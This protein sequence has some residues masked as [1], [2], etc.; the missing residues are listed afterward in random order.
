MT[1]PRCCLLCGLQA[2]MRL[3]DHAVPSL[4]GANAVVL[5]RSKLVGM[6]V[7]M[8]L[9]Q[10]DASVTVC[11]SHTRDLRSHVQR[12]DVVVASIGQAGIVRGEWLKAGAVAVDV[13]FNVVPDPESETGVRVCG[14]LAL[15]EVRRGRVVGLLA[16]LAIAT[17]R[18]RVKS[19]RSPWMRGMSRLRRTGA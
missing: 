16:V 17:P 13:G 14:D 15:Q 6:P 18:W 8:L 12:A 4:R 9:L 5:G 19:P 1:T 7:A 2:V 11:H 3:L 10:R